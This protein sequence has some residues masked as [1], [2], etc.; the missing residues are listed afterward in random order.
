MKREH[1]E[2]IF[3][4]LVIALLYLNLKANVIT[5]LSLS[6]L[7]GDKNDDHECGCGGSHSTAD[8]NLTFP[9]EQS[10]PK[11]ST[12]TPMGIGGIRWVTLKEV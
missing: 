3:A 9:A 1:F 5:A 2:F 11:R 4:I 7:T 6:D 10:E 12:S 8:N